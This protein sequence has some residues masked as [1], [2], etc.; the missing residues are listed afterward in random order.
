MTRTKYEFGST[1]YRNL[2]EM[3][4]AIADEYITAR[5]SNGTEAVFELLSEMP[6]SL[7]AADCIEGFGLNMRD[8]EGNPSHAEFNEYNDENLE[9]AF[10]E[11]RQ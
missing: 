10:R 1:L 9:A 6:D 3:I 11:M 2:N 5:G 7:L 8:D 4:A